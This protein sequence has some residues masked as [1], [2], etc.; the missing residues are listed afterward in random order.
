M[1]KHGGA[2]VIWSCIC[3]LAFFQRLYVGV[4]FSGIKGSYTQQT[5]AIW[6]GSIYLEDFCYTMNPPPPTFLFH[7]LMCLRVL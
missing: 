1:Y 4:E 2:L 7:W 5:W 6:Q 3:L